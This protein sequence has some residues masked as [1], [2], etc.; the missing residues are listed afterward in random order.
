VDDQFFVFG[1]EGASG[2]LNDVYCLDLSK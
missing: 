1:G 2:P